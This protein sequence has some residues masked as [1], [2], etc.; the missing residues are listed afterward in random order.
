MDD[1]HNTFACTMH[2]DSRAPLVSR[3]L[4]EPRAGKL[5]QLERDHARPGGVGPVFVE[6]PAHLCGAL[7]GVHASNEGTRCHLQ[8]CKH[9]W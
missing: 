9:C 7:D 2:A 3:S 4:F 1:N 8:T 5:Q 6:I